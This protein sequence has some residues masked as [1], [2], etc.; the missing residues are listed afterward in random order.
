[1]GHAAG[2][3]GTGVVLD[4]IG[5]LVV[6]W[7][8][9]GGGE[10]WERVPAGGHADVVAAEHA[11]AVGCDG[12]G[13][14]GRGVSV[15]GHQVARGIGIPDLLGGSS[16]V[17]QKLGAAHEEAPSVARVGEAADG[18]AARE[19]F[20]FAPAFDVPDEHPV[21]PTVG[22]GKLSADAERCERVELGPVCGHGRQREVIQNGYLCGCGANRRACGEQDGAGEDEPVEW[23]GVMTG[24]DGIHG[25]GNN[26]MS[27]PGAAGFDH[28]SRSRELKVF[29]SGGSAGM[30]STVADEGANDSN[31]RR[32]T[33]DEEPRDRRDAGGA[34]GKLRV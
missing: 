2:V 20:G 28:P 10:P 1:M 11:E 16:L 24:W 17:R 26:V 7:A 21:V 6:A 27:S 31:T 33:R 25:V 4:P 18:A 14:V 32:T 22:H 30:S 12:G 5:E 19:R 29:S 15:E 3:V 8:R 13:V 9:V 23:A 34:L